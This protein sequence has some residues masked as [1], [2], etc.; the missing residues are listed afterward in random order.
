[1]QTSHPIESFVAVA[2]TAAG[3]VSGLVPFLL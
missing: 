1:M 3:I 2:S